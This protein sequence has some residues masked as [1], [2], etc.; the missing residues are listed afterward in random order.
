MAVDVETTG[1]SFIDDRVIQLGISVFL[2][3]KCV[4]TTSMYI[5]N[6]SVPNNGYHINRISDEQIAS[7][8][9]PEWAFTFLSALIHKYPRVV[10]AYNASFD[11][12]F[13]ANE[14]YRHGIVYDF[15]Q[16]WIVDPLVIWRHFDKS[17]TFGGGKLVNA[18]DKFRIPILKAHDAGA[19]SEAAGHVFLAQR[20]Y[21]GIRGQW[22]ELHARQL[23]WHEEWSSVFSSYYHSRGRVP[24]ITP[25]PYAK[26]ISCYLEGEQ[27]LLF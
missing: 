17:R 14:F 26:E 3:G 9:D 1:L 6:T 15:S 7:G 18:C 12:T 5:R 8:Y 20:A 16:L 10:L 25:W 23:R 2:R 13:L 4:R 27:S 22:S 24:Q 21:Y 19:D 11:L